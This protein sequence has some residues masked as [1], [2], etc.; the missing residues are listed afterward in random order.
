M[1]FSY[2]YNFGW[3]NPKK[4]ETY[5]RDFFSCVRYVVNAELKKITIRCPKTPKKFVI[6]KTGAINFQNI[7]FQL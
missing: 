4:N 5:S 3:A 2:N 7:Y 6:I 1:D